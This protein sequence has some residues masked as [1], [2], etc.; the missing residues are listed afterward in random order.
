MTGGG[1]GLS[2][3]AYDPLTSRAASSVVALWRQPL[4][5]A[6]LGHHGQPGAT[7]PAG[8]L[9]HSGCNRS[10]TKRHPMTRRAP[11]ACTGATGC[12]GALAA[13][14]RCASIVWRWR[15]AHLLGQVLIRRRYSGCLATLRAKGQG[16]L[17]DPS[18]WRHTADHVGLPCGHTGGASHRCPVLVSSVC[19]SGLGD[20]S[21]V[22]NAV[23]CNAKKWLSAC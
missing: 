19:G 18:P 12:N 5:T 3:G 9:L 10:G 6:S 7:I 14:A 22:M 1:H 11:N 16:Q 2:F 17:P 21:P 13:A 8:A 23:K 20:G 15:N 4:Q